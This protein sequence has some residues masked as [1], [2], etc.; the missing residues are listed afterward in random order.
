MVE[1]IA[2]LKEIGPGELG[3]F[4]SLFAVCFMLLRFFYKELRKLQEDHRKELRQEAQHHV[5]RY[6]DMYDK[7]KD[8]ND[9]IVKQ[10]FE[11]LNKNTEA[12]TKLAEAVRNLSNK[13]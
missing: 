3:L 7:Y 5:Q 11:T 1:V 2:L 10:M 9:K 4:G 8:A 13:I 12:N 6:D